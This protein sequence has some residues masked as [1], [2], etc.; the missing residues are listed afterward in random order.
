MVGV[1]FKGSRITSHKRLGKF[2]IQPVVRTEHMPS[3]HREYL[4]YNADEFRMWS[5]NIGSSTEEVVRYFLTSVSAPEQGYKACVSL[6]VFASVME[7]K[8]LKLPVRGC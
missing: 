2:S 3:K 1:Y 5:K 4:K 7:R 8:G 6:K